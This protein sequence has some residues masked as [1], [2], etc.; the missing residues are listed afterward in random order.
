MSRQRL[1]ILF[2]VSL[3]SL[4]MIG[5]KTAQAGPTSTPTATP[6]ATAAP[7]PTAT[8]TAMPQ[9]L[10]FFTNFEDVIPNTV[11]GEIIVVGVSPTTA[12]LGGDAFGGRANIRRLYHSGSRAWMVLPNGT[13]VRSA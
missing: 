9:D 10:D 13:A 6:T 11:P 7:T 12:N 5:A 8:P 3:F 2:L 1:L 4:A